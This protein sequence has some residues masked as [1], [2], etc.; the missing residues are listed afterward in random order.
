MPMKTYRRN[1]SESGPFLDEEER[2]NC[3]FGDDPGSPV[4][5]QD[6]VGEWK[7]KLKIARKQMEEASAHYDKASKSYTNAASWKAKLKKWK[8][9]AEDAHGKAVDVYH[10]LKQ[11]IEALD[12]TKTAETAIAVK[13]VLCLVKD[14]FEDINLL[15]RISTSVDEPMGEIQELKMWIDCN[16]NLEAKQKQDAL[17]CITPFEDKITAANATQELILN[18]LLTIFLNANVLISSVDKSGAERREGLKWQLLDLKRR[19][20]GKTVYTMRERRCH[21]H[22]EEPSLDLPCSGDIVNPSKHYFPIRKMDDVPGSHDSE[23]YAD[24]L[25]L[26]IKAEIKEE[27]AR[28]VLAEAEETRNDAVAYYNGLNDAINAAE[29][30]KTAS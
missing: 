28:L 20:S 6:C 22:H 8:E 29:A 27:V 10:E 3:C 26:F 16:D 21:H 14:I 24:I 19:I 18:N 23:Y 15:L 2:K 11:F 7:I 13:A 17:D 5:P 4:P 30:A 1:S 25:D 12:R 9:N